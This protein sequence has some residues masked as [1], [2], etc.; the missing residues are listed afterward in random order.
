[1]RQAAERFPAGGEHG[2]LAN[3][4]DKSYDH[5]NTGG[6]EGGKRARHPNAHCNL[7][8]AE[9]VI[10]PGGPMLLAKFIRVRLLTQRGRLIA[11]TVLL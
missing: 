11:K 9:I 7:K 8:N 3:P 10:H 4:G 1:M 6:H 5:E 2:R